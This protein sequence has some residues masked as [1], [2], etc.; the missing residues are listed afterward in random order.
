MTL[1]AFRQAPIRAVRLGRVGVLDDEPLLSAEE[2]RSL[3]RAIEA[4]VLAGE[5]LTCQRRPG[6]ATEVELLAVERIG[7]EAW[8]R[9]I[10]ANLRLVRMSAA[11]EARRC[12][13]PEA[14][15]F[16]EGCLG[17]MQALQ[18]FDVRRGCR[19]STYALTWV[20]AAVG[21][22]SSHRCGELNLPVWRA[23][24]LRRARG[25]QGSMT[26]EL[27]RR[28]TSDE[29]AT[30][31]ARAAQWVG[32]LLAHE[33]P[34]SL[35]QLD[36]VGREV[37]DPRLEDELDRVL[38]GSWLTHDLLRGVTQLDRAVLGWRYGFVDGD[39]HSL[40]STAERLGLPAARVR[41]V[42][43]A[44]LARLRRRLER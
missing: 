26:M 16:Q 17:L 33:A 37:A 23:E 12:R 1:T 31:L 10:R 3:A 32:S 18:R 29:L 8:Q 4:G 35:T 34:T 28:P 21:A 24:A 11:R 36:E 2:E 19:F 42:E 22:A 27:G 14:E 13:L 39:C 40:A 7:R 15:L 41:T 25:V 5:A 38:D 20:K 9:F 30:E 6:G 44:A 43:N